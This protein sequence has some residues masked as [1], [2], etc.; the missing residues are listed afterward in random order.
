LSLFKNVPVKEKVTFQLRVEAYN[1]FNHTQFSGV[2]TAARI[3]INGNQ[4][5]G[6]FGQLTSAASARV[7]QFASRVSF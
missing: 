2:N 4:T 7:M 3:D 5:N 1:T 6:L